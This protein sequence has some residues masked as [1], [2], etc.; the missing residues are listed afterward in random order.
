[1]ADPQPQFCKWREDSS[2]DMWNTGCGQA[3]VFIDDGPKE[4]GFKYCCYCGNVL[5]SVTALQ[6]I[7]ED[8]EEVEGKN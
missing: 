1:M 8:A 2:G 5:R 7:D 4:N 6:A 3:F